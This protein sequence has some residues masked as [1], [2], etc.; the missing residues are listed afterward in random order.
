MR[1]I[2][3]F[4]MAGGVGSRLLVL[5]R[6]R[7][8]PAVPFGGKYRIIDFTLSNITNS[9]I[10][11]VGILTQYRPYSLQEHIGVGEP[12]DLDRR[13][14]TLMIL[15]PYQGSRFSDWYRGTADSIYQNLD[16]VDRFSTKGVLILS[17]DHI[18]KMDY[19]R[20]IEFHDEMDADLTIVATT[21]PWE[22]AH[23]FG[24]LIVD[25]N[26]AVE[27]EEKPE[28]PKSNLVNMGIYLFKPEVLKKVLREDARRKDSTHDFGK[29]I[30]P[31]M[32]AENYRV[33]VYQFAGYWRDVGTIYSYW[34]A[35]MELVQPLPPLN[36]Y[37]P[38]WPIYTKQEE[39]P[40]AKFTKNA[41][42]EWSLVSEGCIVSGTIRNSVLSP[43]VLIEED[44]VVE[45][46]IIM[47]N[48]K[49]G[50]G[51]IIKNAIIDKY[52]RIGKEAVI[53]EGDNVPNENYPDL[54]TNGL[55]VIGKFAKIPPKTK[56]GKN[57]I[58]DYGIQVKDEEVPSG[59]SI[60]TNTNI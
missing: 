4:I 55:V 43:G 47:N 8:K 31:K 34:E 17:G 53:G 48:T 20:V 56:I 21:V 19:R 37:D 15:P 38:D 60:L 51:A 49:I 40:P 36:L 46:S 45:N 58:I 6:K 54:M 13:R 35:N 9:G 16:F 23:R 3:A 33:M 18:Y 22:N 24:T 41:H 7:A 57:V 5:T 27:F 42:S 59:K 30:I 39:F 11:I 1:N 28:H 29:D 10:S 52:V 26:R 50:K 25:G 12:W 14:A 2:V 32:I 44:A